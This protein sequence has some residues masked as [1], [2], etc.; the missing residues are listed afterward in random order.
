[1]REAMGMAVDR[2]NPSQDHDNAAWS[3]FC[4]ICWNKIKDR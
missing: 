2:K 4:G 3:Y 1:V